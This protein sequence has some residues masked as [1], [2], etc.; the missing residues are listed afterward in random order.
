MK[1]SIFLTLA[2]TLLIIISGCSDAQEPFL[3]PIAGYFHH[4]SGQRFRYLQVGPQHFRP[5]IDSNNDICL[6]GFIE[7][8]IE[9]DG[10][11]NVVGMTYENDGWVFAR[12]IN[13][14]WQLPAMQRFPT[15]SLT[16]ECIVNCM[17]QVDKFINDYGNTLIINVYDFDGTTIIDT[18]RQPV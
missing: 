16:D 2:L 12:E 18:W 15:Q 14:F 4:P 13:P 17:A 8:A 9:V 10:M 11:I 3:E 6:I 1:K 5:Y 7:K